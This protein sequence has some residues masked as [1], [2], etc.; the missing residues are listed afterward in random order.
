MDCGEQCVVI[1]TGITMK[2]QLCADN[3]DTMSPQV[4]VSWFSHWGEWICDA[5][6]SQMLPVCY[7]V[8]RLVVVHGWCLARIGDSKLGKVPQDERC[9]KL[10]FLSY[11]V[12]DLGSF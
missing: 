3:W 5:A 7:L 9:C 6:R 1:V 11:S 4:E 12:A 2:P 8:M 10:Y